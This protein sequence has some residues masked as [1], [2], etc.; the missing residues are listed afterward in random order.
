MA[1]DNAP[2]NICYKVFT[3]A[4]KTATLLDGLTVIKIGNKE[5]T[6]YEHWCGNTCKHGEKLEQ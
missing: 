6:R 5:A 3:K 1:G 2:M 4:F